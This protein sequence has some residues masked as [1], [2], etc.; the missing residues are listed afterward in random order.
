[1][2]PAPGKLPSGRRDKTMSMATKTQERFPGLCAEGGSRTHTTVRSLRPERSA[3]ANSATSALKP[4]CRRSASGC[5]GRFPGALQYTPVV[6]TR[7]L[8]LGLRLTHWRRSVHVG[9]TVGNDRA[10][11]FVLVALA[12]ALWLINW[13]LLRLSPGIQYRAHSVRIVRSDSA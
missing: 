6:R 10:S 5:Q 11:L 4:Y 13:S 8:I 7:S 2:L 1:M 9:T 3:S 12:F